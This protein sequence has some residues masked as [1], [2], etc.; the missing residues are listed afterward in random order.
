MELILINMK[1]SIYRSQRE[2]ASHYHAFFVATLEMYKDNPSKV[3]SGG[4]QSMFT[5]KP[6]QIFQS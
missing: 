4:L 6:F 1:E 3:T 2:K 5:R